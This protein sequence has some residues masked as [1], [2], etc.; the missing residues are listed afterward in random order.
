M[1]YKEI[2][3]QLVLQTAISGREEKMS[4]FIKDLFS[5]L[6]DEVYVDSFFNVTGIKRGSG[7][8]R[9]LVTAHY[10][11]IGFLV[12]NID[13]KGF[14]RLASVG[15]VDNKILP[16]QEVV[17][18]GKKEVYGVI[19]AKPPHLINVE[20]KKKVAK[21]EELY[22][23]TGMTADSLKKVVS[24][25]DAVT[26]RPKYRELLNSRISAKTVDNRCGVTALIAAMKELSML[27]HESDIY[28]TATT[29]EEFDLAGAIS[30]AY[31]VEPDLAIVI[32][33]CHGN[34]HDAPEDDI[35]TLGRG[36]AIG[37][38]PQLDRI[39][40]KKLF[41]TAKEYNIPYQ[42]DVEAGD[43]GTEAWAVQVSRAGIPTTLISIPV[44]YMHTAIE[45]VDMK[46][47]IN[48]AKLASRFAACALI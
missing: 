13:K 8:G 41:K 22:V 7:K 12:K 20:E 1:D 26:L 9:I 2:L 38:G 34:V 44:R 25:G 16:A 36:P 33:A 4:F 15:G 10:D 37:I 48:T 32:D 27:K 5:E 3:K 40:T 24:I 17:I 42:T 47:I 31:S 30:T 28:F 45:T 6:C 18:H 39:Y 29:Q 11:E 23:D 43:T 35:Y 46:D 19:G 21:L 14:V